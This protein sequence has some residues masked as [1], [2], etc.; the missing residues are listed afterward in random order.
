[1]GGV[2]LLFFK[3]TTKT[4]A[5]FSEPFWDSGRDA[6][7]AAFYHFKATIWKWARIP[8]IWNEEC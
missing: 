7:R 2:F 4:V 6:A 3:A 1:L 8:E 5:A